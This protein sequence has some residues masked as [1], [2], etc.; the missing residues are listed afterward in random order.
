MFMVHTSTAHPGGPL[1]QQVQRNSS[2]MSILA[3]VTEAG[4]F[5]LVTLSEIFIVEPSI[6]YLT[7]LPAPGG[8]LSYRITGFM[9]LGLSGTFITSFFKNK[10]LYSCLAC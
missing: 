2:S 10:Y 1:P 6:H 9:L 5:L 8:T 3:A 4:F 7:V